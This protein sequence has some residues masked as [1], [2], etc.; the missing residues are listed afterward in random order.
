MHFRIQRGFSSK[1]SLIP[2]VSRAWAKSIHRA[3]FAYCGALICEAIHL[4][5]T[6]AL[7][8]LLK[9][10]TILRGYPDGD[11]WLYLRAWAAIIEA[12]RRGNSQ[13]AKTILLAE[14]QRIRNA[15][16]TP[17]VDEVSFDIDAALIRAGYSQPH[18]PKTAALEEH[19]YRALQ[20]RL[21]LRRA[22]ALWDISSFFGAPEARVFHRM[23]CDA[24]R[25]VD[26]V[27]LEQSTI[28]DLPWRQFHMQQ[29]SLLYATINPPLPDDELPSTIRK[30][31]MRYPF[32]SIE[33]AP[34]RLPELPPV[35]DEE[36]SALACPPSE[37]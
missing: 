1:I 11:R 10:R 8:D 36:L 6:D 2:A 9:A 31:R 20:N 12:H 19:K 23:A 4:P 24:L 21:H 13:E 14:R 27:A 35:T 16:P 3:D 32:A 5:L 7:S 22:I 18:L 37:D 29:A 30:Y 26:W 28:Q 34:E 33:D 17:R 25:S 15:C